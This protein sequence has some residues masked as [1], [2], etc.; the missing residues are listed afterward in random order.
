MA[1]DATLLA[2]IDKKMSVLISL[3]LR[4][5]PKKAESLSLREQIGLLFE[6]GMRPSEIARALGRSPGY[7]NKEL[8]GL[9]KG[10]GSRE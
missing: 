2:S 3:L 7:V 10:G 1:E 9:R 6:L 5:I 8:S 4:L